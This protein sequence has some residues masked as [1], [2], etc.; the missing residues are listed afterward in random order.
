MKN[1]RIIIAG[2]GTLGHVFPALAVIEQLRKLEPRTTIVYIGQSDQEERIVKNYSSQVDF[3]KIVSDKLYR[4][5]TLKWFL[6]PFKVLIGLVQSFFIIGNFNPDVVFVK[7]GYLALPVAWAARLINVP[8]IMHETDAAM[9]LANKMIAPLA[10]KI[11]VSFPNFVNKDKKFV[12]T[13]NPVREEFFNIQKNKR[14]DISKMKKSEGQ[15]LL[16]GKKSRKPMIMIMGGSQGAHAINILVKNI[17]PS[18]TRR[19]KVVHITGKADYS[20]FANLKLKHYQAISFT[21]T[22]VQ[23]LQNADLVIS[24]AGGSIFELAA[25]SKPSILI[26]LPTAANNHQRKNAAILAKAQAA[27]VLEQ[28][29]LNSE[30]L[31][32]A[33]NNLM[34]NNKK[35]SQLAK[36]IKKFAQPDAARKIAQMILKISNT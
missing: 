25:M 31:L 2:G 12:Y 19:F 6:V 14:H 3:V 24:R 4:Y 28:I 10:L 9:G 15:G 34:T 33:I 20:V 29:G 11:A 8:I 32:K 36:N 1:K 30:D 35:R 21:N 16:R 18:L 27:V 23:I 13:G 7:G 22:M 26:P 5:P 17:L